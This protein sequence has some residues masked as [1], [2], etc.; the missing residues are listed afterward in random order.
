[1]CIYI[2]IYMH[3]YIYIYVYIH[4]YRV[5][6]KKLSKFEIAL[7]V[8]KRLSMNFFINIDLFGYL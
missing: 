6:Q 7:N 3:I 5:Y 8:A 1:M 4:I 2:H